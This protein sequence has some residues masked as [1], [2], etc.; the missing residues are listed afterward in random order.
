MASRMQAMIMVNDVRTKANQSLTSLHNSK[1][2]RT[3]TWSFNLSRPE[4]EPRI[5]DVPQVESMYF[6]FTHMPG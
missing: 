2:R 1:L 5:L 4:A 3:E 6:V